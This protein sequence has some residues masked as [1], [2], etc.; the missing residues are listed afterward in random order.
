MACT[1][2]TPV[3]FP[4]PSLGHLL[5]ASAAP[6]SPRPWALLWMAAGP[7]DIALPLL[8][9]SIPVSLGILSS[10]VPVLMS[11]CTL[12]CPRLRTHTRPSSVPMCSFLPQAFVHAV[13]YV[14]SVLP[15]PLC[16]VV[17]PHPLALLSGALLGS[18]WA[19]SSASPPSLPCSSPGICVSSSGI[20]LTNKPTLWLSKLC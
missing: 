4:S 13:P 2:L 7:P 1:S 20:L 19:P 5:L 10:W 9:P 17:L 18:I 14:W 6:P 3:S 12:P 15:S 16:L 8:C 11:L